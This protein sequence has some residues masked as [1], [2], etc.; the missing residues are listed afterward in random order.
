MRYVITLRIIRKC[1]R[2][3]AVEY[4]R[5]PSLVGIDFIVTSIKIKPVKL[6]PDDTVA[7]NTRAVKLPQGRV[8]FANTLLRNYVLYL[9]KNITCKPLIVFEWTSLFTDELPANFATDG[10]CRWE[11]S[12]ISLNLGISRARINLERKRIF[13]LRLKVFHD[14][15]RELIVILYIF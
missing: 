6:P 15:K 7:R 9:V 12:K 11:R 2:V 14:Y 8:Y 13:L 10:D 4:C 1:R 3:Y 5:A